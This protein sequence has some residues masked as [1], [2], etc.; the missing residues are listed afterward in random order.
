RLKIATPTAA[1]G[2]SYWYLRQYSHR[3][4]VTFLLPPYVK[5]LVQGTPAPAPGDASVPCCAFL[6]FHR[7][8]T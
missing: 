4:N 1:Q 5:T 3:I 6:D 7:P 2:C 8:I